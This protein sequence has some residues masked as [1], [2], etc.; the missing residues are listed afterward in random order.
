[1]VEAAPL[2]PLAAGASGEQRAV[3]YAA[4]LER[5]ELLLQG[6]RS[7]GFGSDAAQST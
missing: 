4:V 1:M 7:A 3:Q 6:E 5:L 2:P